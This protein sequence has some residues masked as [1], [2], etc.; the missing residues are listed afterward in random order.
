[1]VCRLCTRSLVKVDLNPAKVTYTM[2]LMCWNRTYRW[3][4]CILYCSCVF[5]QHRFEFKNKIYSPIF[6]IFT[7][8]YSTTQWNNKFASIINNFNL[9]IPIFYFWQQHFQPIVWIY[10]IYMETKSTLLSSWCDGWSK[11]YMKA[12]LSSEIVI[13]CIITKTALGEWT[14]PP[15]CRKNSLEF[16]WAF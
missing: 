8:S 7:I 3:H 15:F 11:E 5:H 16:T 6:S 4:G 10:G 9:P 1:M 13:V 14:V 2:L 12:K